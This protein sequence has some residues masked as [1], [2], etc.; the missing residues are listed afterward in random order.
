MHDLCMTGCVTRA[1]PQQMPHME[2]EL[3]I[4]PELMRTPSVFSVVRVPR[5]LVFC[6]MFCRSCLSFRLFCFLPLYC[7]SVLQF[8]I[9]PLKSSTFLEIVL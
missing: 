9:T 5:S 2:H 6:V 3:L 7:L 1:T 8:L 4:L